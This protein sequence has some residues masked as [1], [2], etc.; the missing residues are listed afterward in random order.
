MS[1]RKEG[2]VGPAG[3]RVRP[4]RDGQCDSPTS[5]I[6]A[7]GLS[8]GLFWPNGL[9]GLRSLRWWLFPLSHLASPSLNC[10][11]LPRLVSKIFR[12]FFA[13]L[14][15]TSSRKIAVPFFHGESDEPRLRLPGT[16]ITR[17]ALQGLG[18]NFPSFRDVFVSCQCRLLLYQYKYKTRFLKQKKITT[19][20]C[21]SEKGTSQF[22][23]EGQP[24]SW[25]S[26]I[27]VLLFMK[28]ILSPFQIID[29]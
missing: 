14:G 10:Q 24:T 26:F 11:L 12:S 2:W 27:Q 13:E 7:S 25:Y 29:V 22:S 4:C 8:L 23:L 6:R 17:K 3:F 9:S 21:S 5:L 1:A 20:M 19:L 15:P 28:L 18:Y 16:R